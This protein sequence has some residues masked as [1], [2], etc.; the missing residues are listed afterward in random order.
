MRKQSRR[1]SHLCLLLALA[2]WIPLASCGT[3]ST[4]ISTPLEAAIRAQ[5]IALNTAEPG[6]ADDDL[7]PFKQIVGDASIVGLGEA[8]H[9]AHE[10]F[11]MKT[12]LIEYLVGTLGFTT[13]AMENRWD[14]SL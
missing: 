1:M 4:Q 2:W 12:R 11:T 9:G 13:I 10:F 14:A 8:T 5:A 6:G 3:A 7:L